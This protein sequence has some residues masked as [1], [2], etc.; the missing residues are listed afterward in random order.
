MTGHLLERNFRFSDGGGGYV[1]KTNYFFLV[2]LHRDPPTIEAIYI[3]CKCEIPYDEHLHAQYF[4]FP[5]EVL[6]KFEFG[7][8]FINSRLTK[9]THSSSEKQVCA[10]TK[11]TMDK[12]FCFIVNENFK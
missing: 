2:P 12:I 5:A 6:E 9:L 3:S 10:Q 8:E 4:H 11:L 1:E 7:L